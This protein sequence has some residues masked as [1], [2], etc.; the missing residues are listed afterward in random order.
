MGKSTCKIKWELGHMT[1]PQTSMEPHRRPC[2]SDSK[3][4]L[5]RFHPNLGKGR[6]TDLEVGL[7]GLNNFRVEYGAL[8]TNIWSLAFRVWGWRLR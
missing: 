4:T 8:C 7:S 5:F 3:R 6:L 1:L 2:Q